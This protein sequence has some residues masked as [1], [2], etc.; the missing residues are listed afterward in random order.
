[1]ATDLATVQPRRKLMQVRICRRLALALAVLS[2]VFFLLPFCEPGLVND[3]ESLLWSS[4]FIIWRLATPCMA[5]ALVLM[6]LILFQRATRDV[7]ASDRFFG[8]LFS[9]DLGSQILIPAWLMLRGGG[10]VPGF[11]EWYTTPMLAL[12]LCRA[13]LLLVLSVTVVAG[14]LA[15]KPWIGWAVLALFAAH[16][17]L[18]VWR[19]EPDSQAYHELFVKPSEVERDKTL[20]IDAEDDAGLIAVESQDVEVTVSKPHIFYPNAVIYAMYA[21][22]LVYAFTLR[23]R[24][25]LSLPQPHG[26]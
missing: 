25:A 11:F 21:L 1:M 9:L 16:L 6:A 7:K 20:T 14:F 19:V 18:R 17:V 3:L 8:V 5:L 13:L 10:H 12:V 15:G 26:P 4:P 22:A 23:K 24:S 2:Y